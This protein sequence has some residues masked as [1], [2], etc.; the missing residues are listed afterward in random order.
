MRKVKSATPPSRPLLLCKI[1]IV[2]LG[3]LF[4]LVLTLSILFD[5]TQPRISQER[6]VNSHGKTTSRAIAQFCA[7]ALFDDRWGTWRWRWPRRRGALWWSHTR[8]WSDSLCLGSSDSSF[9]LFQPRHRFRWSRRRGWA[10]R[11]IG[12][13]GRWWRRSGKGRSVSCLLPFA[14]LLCSLPGF[15][16]LLFDVHGRRALFRVGHGD[17]LVLVLVLVYALSMIRCRPGR[18]PG[19]VGFLTC[20]PG[21]GELISRWILRC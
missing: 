11:S 20:V 5:I 10:I 17:A 19:W 13:L 6:R 16:D 21:F 4:L 15:S 14:S 1:R 12:R 3:C 7:D 9:Y 2:T 8:S 18:G